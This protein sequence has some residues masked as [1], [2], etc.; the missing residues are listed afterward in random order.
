MQSAEHYFKSDD[1][2]KALE[3]EK[4]SKPADSGDVKTTVAALEVF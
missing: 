4:Y 3:Y 2:L 1:Q